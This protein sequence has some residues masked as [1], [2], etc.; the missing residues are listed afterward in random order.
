[1]AAHRSWLFVSFFLLE[2]LLL[3][4]AK[5]LT[6]STLSTSH[7]ILMNRVSQILHGSGHNVTKLLYEGGDIPDFRNENSS[8]QIINWR[9][10]EDQQK[11]F[12]NR[13]HQL[14]EEFVYGR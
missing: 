13:W 11:T 14:I 4:A 2:V 6:I 7:Y 12:D 9:L 10:P 8:Y 3:E 1:M 5:I